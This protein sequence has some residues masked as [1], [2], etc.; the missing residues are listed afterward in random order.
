ME[1]LGVTSLLVQM[2]HLSDGE[3]KVGIISLVSI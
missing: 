2:G 1:K 3:E